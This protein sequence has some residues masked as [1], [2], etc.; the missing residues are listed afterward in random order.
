M[1]IISVCFKL[2]LYIYNVRTH[3][4]KDTQVDDKKD[5]ALH[6]LSSELIVYC[7]IFKATFR[8]AS[9]KREPLP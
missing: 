5:Y 3:P 1:L 7:S 8:G 9:V 2:S 6:T 4:G